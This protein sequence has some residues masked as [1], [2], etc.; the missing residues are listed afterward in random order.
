MM[1]NAK[2][3]DHMTIRTVAEDFYRLIYGHGG[4]LGHVT[5]TI[6]ILY[7]CKLSF[8]LPQKALREL[9]LCLTKRFQRRCLKIMAKFMNIAPKQG[10]TTTL[11]QSLQKH[12][13]S[14]NLVICCKFYPLN[15]FVTVLPI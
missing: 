5:W 1:L 14:V 12:K 15:D 4:H 3:Q 9:W 7:L 2:F 11:G 8:P 6:Y 10:Q 13:S